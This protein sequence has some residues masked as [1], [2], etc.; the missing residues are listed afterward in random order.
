MKVAVIGAG[1]S[2]MYAAYLLEKKGYQVTIYEKEE[3]IGG[4]CKTILSKD[5]YT[6]IGTI[7]SFSNKI[8]ELLIDLKVEYQERFIYRH[9]IDKNYQEVEYMKREDVVLLMEELGRLKIIN[10]TYKDSLNSLTYGQINKDLLIPFGQFAKKKSLPMVSALISPLLSSFG[11]GNIDEIATYYVL[12][13]FTVETIYAFIKGDKLLY[14][15]KGM[16][17][18]IRKLSLNISDIRYSLEVTNIEVTDNQVKVETLY[19]S[20]YFDKV[21][22]TSKLPNNVIKD[23]VYNKIMNDIDTNP[24]FTCAYEVN[25]KD[26]VTTYFKSHFGLKEKMQFFHSCK[27]NGRRMVIT[28]TYGKISKEVIDSITSDLKQVGVD[29]KQLITIKQWYIFPHLRQ[30]NLTEE[31]YKLIQD[32]QQSSPICLIGSLIT[33]P[34]IDK[35][36][37]SVKQSINTIFE[38]EKAA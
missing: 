15:N 4:H 29:I 25:N 2:G 38:N 36:Y 31:Y 20:D 28:Y 16:S 1:F 18:L 37:L 5:V 22:I 9:F 12:K 24:F 3:Q 33:E 14:L 7:F 10:S 11:F 32:H 30:H 35:L 26:L 19:G 27:H 17:E 21:L 13:V 6:E 23:E 8:K 34:S